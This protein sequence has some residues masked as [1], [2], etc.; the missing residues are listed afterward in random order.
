ME[1][2]LAACSCGDDRKWYSHCECPKASLMFPMARIPPFEG[3]SQSWDMW[4]G[5]S[6][7]G[8]WQILVTFKNHSMLIARFSKHYC[9]NS[10]WYSFSCEWAKALGDGAIELSN[11]TTELCLTVL[12]SCCEQNDCRWNNQSIPLHQQQPPWAWPWEDCR[13]SGSWRAAQP[14]LAHLSWL[15]CYHRSSWNRWPSN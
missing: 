3:F 11:L 5:T 15:F 1:R 10:F 7:W 14:G 6:L 4:E 13:K 9:E 2:D 12:A 8:T